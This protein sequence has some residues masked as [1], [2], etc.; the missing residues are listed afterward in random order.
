MATQKSNI[1]YIGNFR[2]HTTET[3]IAHAFEDLGYNVIRKGRYDSV[4]ELIN[5]LHKQ[6]PVLVL[7]GKYNNMQPSFPFFIDEARCPVV[8]WTFDL[9]WDLP[10]GIRR[11][12]ERGILKC[13]HII[14]T[15]AGHQ[16]KW[17]KFGA[18][19]H[20]IRQ[21]IHGP[22]KVKLKREKDIDVLFVGGRYY[23]YREGLYKFLGEN[24][25]LTWVGHDEEVRG[26][27]LNELIARSKVVVGDSVPSPQY[28]SNRVY[29][30]TGRGGFII[31]PHVEGIKDE[32]PDLVTYEY[33]NFE[34]LKEKIDYYLEHEKERESILDKCHAICPTYKDRVKELCKLIKI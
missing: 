28:W 19:H 23:K 20:V 17:D 32:V 15:D 29:E 5:I 18:N 26:M 21:G 2:K 22:E 4:D 33:G 14:T 8:S 31:H 25:N 9:Y 3:Y 12:P 11:F 1:L 10:H 16:Y 34:D 6:K 7:F 24:Y 27:E 30:I 13:S